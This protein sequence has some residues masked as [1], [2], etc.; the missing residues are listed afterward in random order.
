MPI[1]IKCLSK[2]FK[3]DFHALGKKDDC[4]IVQAVALSSSLKRI[5]A[6]RFYGR[7]GFCQHGISLVIDLL[8]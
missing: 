7:A 1:D 6:H 5:D 4:K 3:G 2:T 8:R